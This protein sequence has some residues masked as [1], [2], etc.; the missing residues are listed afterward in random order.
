MLVR[1]VSVGGFPAVVLSAIAG[2]VCGAQPRERPDPAT[3]YTD[4]ELKLAVWSMRAGA[5]LTQ[6]SWPN[7]AKAAV[8]LSWEVDNETLA[9]STG[10]HSPIAYS[11][12]EYGATERF[13][14]VLKIHD[15]FGVPGTFFVP[16]VSA[17]LAPRIIEEAAAQV[18]VVRGERLR[19]EAHW[20]PGTIL[21]L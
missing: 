21:F 1:L 18:C 5:R 17:L 11:F 15:K 19:Q 12:G 4:Q 20:L 16:A 6:N 3:Q 13:D 8:C 2:N 10:E 9:L 7:G 14:R